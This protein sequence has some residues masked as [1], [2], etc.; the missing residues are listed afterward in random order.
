MVYASRN[1]YLPNPPT[2]NPKLVW[3][4]AEKRNFIRWILKNIRIHQAT[5]GDCAG[6]IQNI[7]F[8]RIMVDGELVA[9]KIPGVQQRR[10]DAY[11]I[12][13]K[14]LDKAGKINW[15]SVQE[16]LDGHVMQEKSLQSTSRKPV[17][18]NIIQKPDGHVMQKERSL[19]STSRKALP[20]T[21][22][23]PS[24]MD[25]Q[26]PDND[27]GFWYERAEDDQF[28]LSLST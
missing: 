4:K 14:N 27:E 9:V 28:L 5:C 18:V 7:C 16:N 12:M 2:L 3:T 19:Q 15:N 6:T 21:I 26:L 17:K 25:V 22:T 20:I 8:W 1:R 24:T 10:A 23:I 13:A 11:R